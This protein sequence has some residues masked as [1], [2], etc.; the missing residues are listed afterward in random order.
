MAV[1]YFTGGSAWQ[2]S[3]QV[4]L[5]A[6]GQARVEGAAVLTNQTLDVDSAEVQLVAGVIGRAA[7]PPRPMM[8]AEA[9]VKSRGFANDAVT[10][11]RVGDAHLYTMPGRWTLR[12]GVI[13]SIALFEPATVKIE[14]AYVVR[15]Q[16]PYY[17]VL[18]PRGDETDEPVQ[19]TY[20]M[21]RPR[22]SELGDR[23]LPAGIARI[24]TSDSAGRL[25]LVGEAATNHAP[26]GKDLVLDAATAFDLTARRIQTNYVSRRDSTRTGVRSGATADYRVT[27]ANA[28]EQPVTIDVLEERAGDWSVVSSSAPAEKVSSTV[29]R[30]R[31]K[32][33]AR[34]DATL[35]YRVNVTW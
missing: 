31:V 20:T 24:F 15:G 22:K 14:R 11:E 10:Q 1:G 33:P 34:G 8:A 21:A 2:A 3:Y 16:I 18:M 6:T 12:P 32:V 4:V 28:G 13:S 25:Q 23:P 35:T 17:G 19:V 30:F 26:A 29:T 5:G 7:A 9:M 27:L